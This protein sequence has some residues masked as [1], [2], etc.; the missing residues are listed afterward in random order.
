M[1]VLDKITLSS[2]TPDQY[3]I[4]K[5]N[6]KQI[7]VHHTAGNSNPYEVIKWWQTT[8]ERVG[9][10]FVIGGAADASL[11]WKDGDIIQ[12]FNTNSW[13]YHLGLTA[14]HL[15][16]GNPGAQSNILLNQQSIGIEICSWGQLTQTSKGYTSY[17]G[18]IVSE[19]Q[20]VTY[21][22]PY[23]GYKSYHKYSDA[24]LASLKELLQ[25]L[26]QKW[27]IPTE[28]KGDEMFDVNPRALR[29][30]PGI[31]THTSVRPDKFDCHPQQELK[32][33]LSSL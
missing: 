17:A 7:Y 19:G 18:A 10:S 27:N 31:W 8:P 30:E 11:K 22:L 32:D 24:Q 4:D 14:A 21:A 2:L 6:K 28:Y 3:F 5:T 12:C 9:V 1:S 33:V 23:K 15:A 20:V 25:F 26:S 29:G 16:A 13:C